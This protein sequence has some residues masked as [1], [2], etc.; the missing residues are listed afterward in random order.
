VQVYIAG[1]SGDDAPIRRLRGFQR[2]HLKAGESREVKFTIAADDI[3]K[4]KVEIC[5]GG[6]QPLGNTPHVKGSL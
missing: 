2:I 1:G 3:P 4:G 5:V 6:G